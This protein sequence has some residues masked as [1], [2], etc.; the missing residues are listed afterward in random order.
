MQPP[1]PL[2]YIVGYSEAVAV[3]AKFVGNRTLGYPAA[4]GPAGKKFPRR[5]LEIDGNRNEDV[6]KAAVRATIGLIHLRPG[7]SQ[8]REL[9]FFKYQNLCLNDS[10]GALLETEVYIRSPRNH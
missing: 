4:I 9:V 3:S 2:I 6:W 5:W 1:I 8:V 10:G 7:I